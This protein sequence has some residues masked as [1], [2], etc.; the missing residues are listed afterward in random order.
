MNAQPPTHCHPPSAD[1]R[2]DDA[3]AK[4]TD[5]ATGLATRPRTRNTP[6]PPLPREPTRHQTIINQLRQTDLTQTCQT[7][8]TQTCRQQPVAVE[9]LVELTTRVALSPPERSQLRERTDRGDCLGELARRRCVQGNRDHVGSSDGRS[10]FRYGE[11]FDQLHG[12]PEDPLE[13]GDAGWAA[14]LQW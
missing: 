12:P 3:A 11:H 8:V 9:H 7:A 2:P 5:P 6:Q 14:T 13:L 4:I 1:Q 10:E